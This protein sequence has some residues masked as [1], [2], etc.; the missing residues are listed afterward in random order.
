MGPSS[1][2][3]RGSWKFQPLKWRF[4]RKF[5]SVRPGDQSEIG[6]AGPRPWAHGAATDLVR[7]DIEMASAYYSTVFEQTSR[8]RLEDCSRFQQLSGLGRRRRRVRDRG[9]QDR[10][11]GRSRSEPALPG[12]AGPAA[13]P[14]VVRPRTFAKL[15]VLRSALTADHGFPGDHMRHGGLGRRP[16]LGRMAGDVRLRTRST[17]R[18]DRDTSRLVRQMARIT[19]DRSGGGFTRRDRGGGSLAAILHMVPAGF[20]Q[21][22]PDI[23]RFGRIR[24]LMGCCINGRHLA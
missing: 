12:A 10:Q 14:G 11:Y 18:A 8:G 15:R 19:A 13:S 2:A 5:Q 21:T 7:S 6:W 1:T 3:R 24:P 9:R 4:G 22:G 20:G 17:R 16:R 23:G